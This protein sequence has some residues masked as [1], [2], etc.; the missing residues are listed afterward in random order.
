MVIVADTAR[1]S[2]LPQQSAPPPPPVTTDYRAGVHD[3][4]DSIRGTAPDSRDQLFAMMANGAYAPESPQYAQALADAGWTALEPHAD[5]VSLTDQHG[6]RI[7]IDPGLLSDDRSG[8]H[9]EIYQHQDGGY[10]VAY[11][12]SELGSKPSQLMDWV[13]N[14][15]QGLGMDASQYS[16]AIELAKRAEHVLGDGNV[17]LTGHSLGGGLASAAS[18]ATGASAVTFNS[19]GLSNNTLESLGFNPNAARESV[20]ESGQVRRYAVNGDPLTGAQEDVPALPIVGSPPTAVGHAL[21]IDPPAGTSFGG[22]HGGGGPDA[23]YVEAFDHA[24]PTDPALGPSIGDTVGAGVNRGI[25]TAG[26]ALATGMESLGDLMRNGPGA[27]PRSWVVGSLLN[28]ASSVVDAGTDAIGDVV[29]AT[30]AFGTDTLVAGVTA[31]G[32]LQF[33]ALASGIREVV[34]LG[35]DLAGTA[36]ELGTGFGEFTAGVA[37]GRGIAASYGLLG[38]VADA[39]IGTVGDVVDG[40]VSLVGETAQNT[41]NAT[42]GFVRDLG[43]ITGLQTP[44]NAVA[45]FVE[46]TGDVVGN[47]ADGIGSAVDI[48]TDKLGDGVEAVADLAGNVAQGVNDFTADV[49]QGVANGARDL[50]RGIA[51]GA[52]RALDAL[53]PFN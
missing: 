42:G 7:P 12:G 32:D 6:N 33:N 50:G 36:S 22:L 13:N 40:A 20:A 3:L 15:Q 34:D 35:G 44:A 30:T 4:S 11:R 47:V 43:R 5:G 16:S 19:S 18:L 28:G 29:G 10:V 26:D 14:G 1:L 9:A 31:V 51:N 37:D 8:F 46:G 53:N 52:G 17:A 21:R 2:A 41:A 38:D 39:S 25:D 49:A 45:G 23:V 48:A 27:T 24:S